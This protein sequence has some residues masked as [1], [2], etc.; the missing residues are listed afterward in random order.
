MPYSRPGGHPGSGIRAQPPPRRPGAKHEV[1]TGQSGPL[2]YPQPGLDGEHNHGVVASPPRGHRVITDAPGRS[3]RGPP[4]SL[5]TWLRQPLRGG[6]GLTASKGQT[7]YSPFSTWRRPADRSA[8]L[9]GEL[10][11]SRSDVDGGVATIEEGLS[12]LTQEHAAREAV[13]GA[14][15]DVFGRVPVGSRD[16]CRGAGQRGAPA[17]KRGCCPSVGTQEPLHPFSAAV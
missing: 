11:Q 4:S 13:D 1:S 2:G 5:K 10:S 16:T 7:R 15:N 9:A 17:A 12:L 6:P 14:I 8:G 3:R